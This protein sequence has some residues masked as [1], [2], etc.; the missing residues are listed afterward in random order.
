MP[1]RRERAQLIHRNARSMPPP[2]RPI[3]ALAG[4]RTSRN[5]S[6]PVWPSA[7]IVCCTGPRAA[8]G[9]SIGTRKPVSSRRAAPS[10]RAT[11]WAVLDER[12][13]R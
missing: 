8:P 11:T 12:A 2:S 6:T 9:A 4:R 10:T 7:M 3:R 5:S 13:R 1:P